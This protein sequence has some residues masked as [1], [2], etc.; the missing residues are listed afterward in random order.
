MSTWSAG[1][2]YLLPDVQ[3]ARTIEVNDGTMVDLDADRRPVGIETLDHGDWQSAL[4]TLAM[5]GRLRVV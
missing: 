2:V 3:I 4:V 5:A 1:Y